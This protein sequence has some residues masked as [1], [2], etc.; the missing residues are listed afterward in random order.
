MPTL[1]VCAWVKYT[2]IGANQWAADTMGIWQDK[3]G[4]TT[5]RID[6][7]VRE[8]VWEIAQSMSIINKQ[9]AGPE[10]CNLLIDR[11]VTGNSHLAC[12]WPLWKQ[13]VADKTNLAGQR[14][15]AALDEFAEV[16]LRRRKSTLEDTLTNKMKLVHIGMNFIAP[17]LLL[18]F[19]MMCR[20]R[21]RPG[22][23]LESQVFPDEGALRR[24]DEFLCRPI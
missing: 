14:L 2:G 9:G 5:Q 19:L 8:R 23:N 22:R 7:K 10:Q 1:Q 15:K 16:G 13:Y 17:M 24:L 3:G 12:K 21:R 11:C 18:L 6:N 4:L 20:Y